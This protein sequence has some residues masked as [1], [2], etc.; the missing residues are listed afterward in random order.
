MELTM[1]LDA[2]YPIEPTGPDAESLSR[3]IS[4]A[5]DI[6]QTSGV[7]RA[8]VAGVIIRLGSWKNLWPLHKRL[9]NAAQDGSL[10]EQ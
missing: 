2:H 9:L 3:A 8:E 10:S 7:R 4:A 5:I 6:F 1:V